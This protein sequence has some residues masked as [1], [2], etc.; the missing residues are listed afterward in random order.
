[1]SYIEQ[2][3]QEHLARRH[4]LYGKMLLP[5]VKLYRPPP[6]PP[7]PPAPPPKPWELSGRLPSIT[8]LT[9]LLPGRPSGGAILDLVSVIHDVKVSD[10][11]SRRRTHKFVLARA[12]AIA[13]MCE[14]R[15]DMSLPQIGRVMGLRDHTTIMHHRDNWAKTSQRIPNEVAAV[16]EQLDRFSQK[17]ISL[18]AEPMVG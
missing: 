12:H 18:D 17:E 1:M 15:R 3:K 14:Y 2:Y 13:M 8:T 6:P 16:H 7:P 4:R 5:I 9:P 11:L 10:I